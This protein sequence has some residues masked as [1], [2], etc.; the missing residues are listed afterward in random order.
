MSE[1]SG[2][3]PGGP[4]S[5][6]R[7]PSGYFDPGRPDYC[8]RCGTRTEERSRG[9]VVRPTCPACGWVYYARNATGAALLIVD[10]GAVLLVQR[11]HEPFRGQWMLP[12]GFVEYGEFAEESAVREAMEET[13][14]QV[15]L[16]GPLGLLLR[17]RRPAQRGPPG[18]LRGAAGG[19]RASGRRRCDRRSLLPARRDPRRDRVQDASARPG[20]LARGPEPAGGAADGALARG[21]GP[22]PGGQDGRAPTLVCRGCYRRQPGWD[23]DGSRYGATKAVGTAAL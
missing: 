9:G 6:Q 4:Q 17:D 12:A 10:G 21:V 8:A 19:R 3:Q 15:E 23:A 18:G 14:L 11:A 5:A 1:E 7:D 20:R 22:T 13:N 2:I 16:T